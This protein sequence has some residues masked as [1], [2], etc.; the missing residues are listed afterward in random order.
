VTG[1][2]T[3]DR[4][5]LLLLIALAIGLAMGSFWVFDV[6]RRGIDDTLPAAISS[7][8][9]YTVEKFS[10]VRLS[11][12][13]QARYNIAG[14]KL[15]HYPQSD[16]YEIQQPLLKNFSAERPPMLLRANRAVADPGNS[17]IHLYDNV[18]MDRAAANG[19]EH[20]HL[21][22]EYLLVLPDDDVVQTDKAVD[23]IL[24]TS[25]LSGAG[26]FANDAT[27]EFRLVGN[28]RGRYQAAPH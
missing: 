1:Q 11:K 24:G 6:M 19:S 12:T 15:T 20:F 25:H 28:V 13:G 22:S 5:R 21:T 23:I 26:M 8:P 2:R 27:R 9:D 7:E 4:F 18:Q 14:A 16:S 17:K 3:A 10:L